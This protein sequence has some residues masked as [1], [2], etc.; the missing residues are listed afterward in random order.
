[1]F[2]NGDNIEMQRTALDVALAGEIVCGAEKDLVLFLG[3]A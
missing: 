3:N 2:S 1:V